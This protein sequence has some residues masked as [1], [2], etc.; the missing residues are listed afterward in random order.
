MERRTESQGSARPSEQYFHGS[1]PLSDHDNDYRAETASI[2]A[3]LREKPQG[4]AGASVKS[5]STAGDEHAAIASAQEPTMGQEEPRADV[6]PAN[7]V[8]ICAALT[9][10]V[11]CVGLV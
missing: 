5:S 8:L 10:V 6:R 7:V 2:T 11:M 3:I 9:L 4:P 1:A